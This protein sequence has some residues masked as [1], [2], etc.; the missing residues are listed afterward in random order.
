MPVISQYTDFSDLYTGLLNALR[1]DTSQTPTV[2]QAKRYINIALQDMHLGTDQ[3]FPTPWAERNGVIRTRPRYNTGTIATTI[4]S[5]TVTGT[6]TLWN[7]ANDFSEN[8]LRKDS[9]K[10]VI[11]GSAEVYDVSGVASDTNCT[12]SP[13]AIETIASGASYD[14]FQDEYELA[15]DFSNLVGNP[16]NFDTGREISLIDRTL[17]RAL[18]PRNRIPGKPKAATLIALG[19]STSVSINHRVRFAPPPDATYLFPYIYLTTHLAMTA[20]GE[21]S[22]GMVNDGD[23]PIVPLKYRHAILFHALYHWYIAKK[24]DPRAQIMKGEYT[25]I[26]LR[27]QQDV[28]PADRRARLQPAVSGYKRHASH[29]YSSRGRAARFDTGQF[30]RLE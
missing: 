30:D 21:T 17:F 16:A 2:N 24:N 18:Y 27:V 12:L 10:M 20:Q 26:I 13:V 5:D 7:T 3:R 15:S 14:S 22:T 9:S 11:G 8:N 1:L 28:G 29:P 6:S 19:P 4:G 23:Q 25:D